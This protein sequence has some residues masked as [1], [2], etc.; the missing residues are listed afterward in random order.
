MFAIT[1]DEI[2]KLTDEIKSY[3]KL[4]KEEELERTMAAIKIHCATHQETIT[5]RL[6]A[7]GLRFIENQKDI[8][9]LQTRQAEQQGCLQDIKKDIK[10][11]RQDINDMKH[12]YLYGRPTWI[13]LS[14]IGLAIA[15]ISAFVGGL[16]W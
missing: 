9:A 6:E 15:I 14:V 12:D 1:P 10:H 7:G 5:K 2:K 11:I 3:I 4:L 16:I 13:M 8:A